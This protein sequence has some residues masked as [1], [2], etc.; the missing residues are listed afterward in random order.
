LP[1]ALVQKELG[2]TAQALTKQITLMAQAKQ[3]FFI[4]LSMIYLF[5][6]KQES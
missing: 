4:Y 3:I 2:P 1:S 5:E 6:L